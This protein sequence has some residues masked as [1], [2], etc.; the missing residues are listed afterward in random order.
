ME[1]Q[2]ATILNFILMNEILLYLRMLEMLENDTE[3]RML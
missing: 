1:R 2:C 3:L